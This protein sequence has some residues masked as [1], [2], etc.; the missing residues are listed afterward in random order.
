[1]GY[2]TFNEIYM[3]LLNEC[4]DIILKNQEK[5]KEN[6]CAYCGGNNKNCTFCQGQGYILTDEM[7]E[8]INIDFYKE[9]SLFGR[10][11]N[12]MKENIFHYTTPNPLH[13][14]LYKKMKMAPKCPYCKGIGKSWGL[15]L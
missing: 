10:G 14:L 3:K 13:E 5:M 2:K 15:I 9:Y 8:L 12:K 1:M 11:K 7:K 4:N 6:S